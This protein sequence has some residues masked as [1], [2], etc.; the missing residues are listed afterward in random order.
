[1][2]RLKK[3]CPSPESCEAALG[4]SEK[5]PQWGPE[6]CFGYVLG[7]GST[8]AVNCATELTG[9]DVDDR[10]AIWELPSIGG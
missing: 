6:M 1:M 8:M 2:N 9:F 7:V 3:P 10:L 5:T 4:L